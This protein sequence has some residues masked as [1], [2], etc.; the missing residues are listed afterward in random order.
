M[1][2]GGKSLLI[3]G[4]MEGVH[5]LWGGDAQFLVLNVVVSTGV[6]KF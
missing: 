2:C 5:T 3:A 1:L 4:N 6:S